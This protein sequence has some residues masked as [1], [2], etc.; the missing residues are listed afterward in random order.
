MSTIILVFAELYMYVCS[1]VHVAC[2]ACSLLYRS[3][4]NLALL[5]RPTGKVRGLV[6]HR[7]APCHSREVCSV[8]FCSCARLSA[9][10]CKNIRSTRHHDNGTS[11]TEDC[12]LHTSLMVRCVSQEAPPET[13][14]HLVTKTH[15]LHVKSL[16]F[17]APFV[18]A[19]HEP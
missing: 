2:A 6:I 1:Q 8:L 15:R 16:G 14:T 17:V 19:A 13:R 11:P 3:R 9:K 10:R 4:L 7:P 12:V 5:R 18:F